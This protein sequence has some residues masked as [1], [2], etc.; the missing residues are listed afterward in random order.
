MDNNANHSIDSSLEQQLRLVC[1]H[2]GTVLMSTCLSVSFYFRDANT[3]EK[4]QA[5]LN[6]LTDY[7][8]MMAGR[9]NWTTNPQTGGWK[10]LRNKPYITPHDWL[11]SLSDV[12]W[13]FIYHGGERHRDAS[14]I[15]FNILANATWEDDQGDLSW[16]TINFPLTFFADWPETAQDVLL[17]WSAEL[18]PLHGLASL[19]TTHNHFDDYQHE[20]IEYR[21]SQQFPGLDISNHIRHGLYLQQGIK[22]VN[23]LTFLHQDYLARV[24]GL[25]A[26]K[27]IKGL[28]VYQA[29]EVYLLQAANKPALQHIPDTYYQ[30]GAV[31]KPIRSPGDYTVHS[32]GEP[33]EVFWS[34]MDYE[35][36]LARFDK[37]L[38]TQPSASKAADTGPEQ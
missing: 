17:R 26:L 27:G 34:G 6:I 23:W 8:T 24:G 3:P 16:L 31:L 35:R 32:L 14:D 37:D 2:T 13:E 5:V 19:A 21:W 28:T 36:W 20:P 9:I 11:P 18:Q 22:G 15:R 29:G 4:R 38:T 7:Q 25:D 12:P 33:G 10:N 30:L 1:P